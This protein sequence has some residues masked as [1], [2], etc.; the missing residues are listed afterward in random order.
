MLILF[1]HGTPA[2][3]TRALGS[4]TVF[5]AQARGWDRLTDG[6]LLTAAEEGGFDLLVT[7]DRRIRYQQNLSSRKIEIVVLVGTTKWSRI[8][9]H[10]ERISTAVEAAA[11][12]TY[13]EVDIPFG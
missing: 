2:G 1:D 13:A 11:P 6:A 12:G 8:R 4:H 9:E 10:V 3:L 5:K 7:I